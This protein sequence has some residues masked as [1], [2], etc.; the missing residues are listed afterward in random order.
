[1]RMRANPFRRAGAATL[2]I[3]LLALSS[4]GAQAPEAMR[5]FSAPFP[6]EEFAARRVRVMERIGDAIAVIQGAAEKPSEAEFRQSNQF[7]YLTGVDLPRAI[8]VIDGRSRR[9]TLYLP[10]RNRA[11]SYGPLLAPG[12]DAARET[13]IEVVVVR[14]SFAVDLPRLARDGRRIITPH[15][16][17]VLGNGSAGDAT[18]FARATREDP[19]DGR[20][21]R[22]DAFIARMKAAAPDAPIGDLDPVLDTLRAIK[23]PR[24]IALIREATRITGLGIMEAIRD[25][26]PGMYEYELDAAARYVF[27]KHGAQGEAYFALVATGANMP[28][29]H[30]HKG[31]SRLRDGDLVQFDYAPDYRYYVSDVTRVFPANGKFSARQRE[32]YEVYLRLYQALLTS[33]RPRVAPRD[34]IKAAVVKM[35]SVM[36]TYPFSDAA[37]R[38]A[39]TAF[40]E[41]YRASRSNSLG[42]TIG[43]EV[44]D[45]R[46]ASDVLL[47]GHIFTIEPAMNLAGERVGLRLEDV[48]LITETGYENLSAF[49]PVEIADIERLMAQPG[50]SDAMLKPPVQRH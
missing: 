14:D 28:Y 4:A 13:G 20:P 26:R 35:D 1:M 10:A 34:I 23:S 21:S 50:L 9:S 22:E 3:L 37:I 15:R 25:A 11:N 6:P 46:L 29:S 41:R 2:G 42:H 32:L 18:A 27:R 16:A 48:I 17:E 40:V 49:V 30:Y 24:E 36:A 12:P 31:T 7:H 44:H 47:P 39:A 38:T 45:V 19:W 8:L 33:I 5:V 43:M